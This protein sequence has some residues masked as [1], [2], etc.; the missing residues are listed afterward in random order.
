MRRHGGFRAGSWLAT[1]AMVAT[2]VA[3][4][5][6]C[7]GGGKSAS[8]QKGQPTDKTTKELKFA[9]VTNNPS[10]FWKIA[11]KGIEKA[12]LERGISVDV[13]MP[14]NG[15]V[16]EQNKILEDLVTQGYDGVAISVLAPADQ[17]R[18]LNRA[19]EK[20]Y[21]ITHDS[22][23]AK[24]QRLA[25]IGTNNFEAGKVLGKRIRELLP[26]GG[27]MAVFVGTL[28][29]DNARERLRGIED[30]IQGAGI[31]IVAK[32][33]DNKDLNKARTNVEDVINALPDVKLLA[34]LW[35]Y[36]GPAILAAVK[37]SNK[38]GAL[39]IAV[40]DEEEGTLTGVDDGHI[41]CTVVQ[42]PYE[43]GYRSAC[44]LHDLATKGK[45]ALPKDPFIDTGVEVITK[46]NVKAFRANL[47]KLKS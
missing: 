29:A 2:L 30:S 45:E 20:L 44:L 33:E 13:K 46:E 37:G 14:Q 4:N 16:E 6:G 35:S 19:A 12:E 10:E 31:E 34:G 41:A 23:A 18:E 21:L 22:D 47:A 40:F 1:W 15:K 3:L 9:F 38:L 25:Y 26:Q 7:G 28:S 24:S 5:G 32:K 42:K 36:N 27:K 8:G 17:T 11:E 43:F 39:H